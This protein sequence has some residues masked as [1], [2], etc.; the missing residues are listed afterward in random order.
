MKKLILL[1]CFGIISAIA[2][3][4]SYKKTIYIPFAPQYRPYEAL[5]QAQ[6][7]IESSNRDSALNRKELAYGRMQ[8]RGIRLKDYEQRTGKHY[9]LEDCF[10]EKTTREIW[11]YYVSKF[12]YTD[13]D[14]FCKEWNGRGEGYKEYTQKVKK[15]LKYLEMIK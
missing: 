3:T 13:I 9:T 1:L 10:N 6:G 2:G 11:F 4:S 12:H 5:W 15:R 14:G 8:I 7:Y